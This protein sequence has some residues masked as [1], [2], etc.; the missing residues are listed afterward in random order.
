VVGAGGAERGERLVLGPGEEVEDDR[1]VGEVPG[2]RMVG[3]R[4]PPDHRREFGGAGAARGVG[5]RLVAVDNF[6]ERLRAAALI[7]VP[8]GSG[9][10]L[11]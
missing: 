6:S 5:Q 9:D 1:T 7:E 8:L 4:Q 3:E 2:P 11:Q 10:D